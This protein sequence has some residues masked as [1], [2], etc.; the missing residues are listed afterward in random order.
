M[1][2]RILGTLEVADGG[3]V[4]ANLGSPKQRALLA[5]LVLHAGEV[6][7]VD[8]MIDA[9]WPEHAPRTAAH[10]VQ[11]Y[12]S[13]LR[14][15]L[16]R[17]A[18]RDLIAT[19]PS[20]YELGIDQAT[21]DAHRFE[22]LVGDA[23]RCSRD[24]DHE[25]AIDSL[26][27]ALDLWCGPVL[28]DFTYEEF[29]QPHIR[30]L[31][32]RYV[33]AL[34]DLAD[35]ELAAGQP[36]KALAAAEM[37]MAEEPLRERARGTA[38]LALYRLGRHPE[39]LR[40]FENLR[41][42]LADELGLEPS[43]WLQRMQ[44]RIV[45]HDPVLATTEQEGGS[46]GPPLGNPYKGLRP[47][48][49]ADVAD[50]FGR[51]SLVGQLVEMLKS[52]RRLTTIVGPSGSGKSSVLAAGL[53]PCVRSGRAITGSQTWQIVRV[54][55]D[56]SLIGTLEA[57]LNAALDPLRDP[58]GSHQLILIDQFEEL[59]VA[60]NDVVTARVLQLLTAAVTADAPVSVVIALR[61]DFYDRPLLEADFAA[62]FAP[63]VVNVVP[64]TPEELESA[65]VRPAAAAGC[66]VEPRL[67][68]EL[69]A[70]T[71]AQAGALPLVQYALTERFERRS[72][73]R[74]T[75]DDY[76]ALGGLRG[77]L[78]RQ[79]DG[80]YE[81]LDD[82]GQLVA[83]QV[84]LRLVRPVHDKMDL[85]RRVPLSELN[86][87]GLDVVALSTVLEAYGR[88]R[89]IT[90]DR[91]PVTGHATVDLAHEALLREWD[92]FVGWIGRHRASLRRLASLA[93]AADDW[94]DAGRDPDYLLVGSRLSDLDTTPLGSVVQLTSTQRAYLHASRAR[95]DCERLTEAERQR[96]E[97]R[98]VH[99]ARSRLVALVA[100]FAVLAGTI[101]YFVVHPSGAA[102]ASVAL[103]RAEGQ[104][105]WTQII[106]QGFE[107]AVSERGLPSREAAVGSDIQANG[108]MRT[109][110]SQGS[111]LVVV[112]A[113]DADVD[114]V[115]HDF[116]SVH[117]AVIDQP[118]MQ[119]NVTRI[120]FA[121]NE[122]SFLAGVVAASRTHTGTIAFIG[123]A[124]SPVIWAWAAG[125]EAGARAVNPHI[126]ILTTY[127]GGA[128]DVGGYTDLT[129]AKAA[130]TSAYNTGADIIFAAAGDSGLGAFAA[131]T[132]PS[133]NGTQRW[134]IGV[135]SDQYE[136]VTAN[137]ANVD[138]IIW[139][140]HILTSVVKRTDVAVHDLVAR[141]AQGKPLTHIEVFSPANH[142]A[143]VTYSGGFI[144][145]L[146]A[147]IDTWRQ[148]I[149]D[150]Q[151][152]VP[153][154]PTNRVAGSLS[155]D[156]CTT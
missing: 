99:R 29:A 64:L 3:V 30:R 138:S 60:G 122:A 100:T 70:D 79:A 137:P 63:S 42:H 22:W 20:G 12:V 98:L 126:T 150:H 135:D 10:S 155:P 9:L 53:V 81:Q 43:P 1:Q 116:P 109:L 74:L 26:R 101:T 51:E 149:A 140:T 44:E 111:G 156:Y 118:T 151:I 87:L 54:V 45:L 142:G 56:R 14:K 72:D 61:A 27:S 83:V 57:A 35:A 40:T 78:S 7:S 82:A 84:F 49:E 15:V 89:L 25:G 34:E 4:V 104:Y 131:A 8:R 144:D 136:T 90:F 21:V 143:D 119:P 2:F 31:T 107:R 50:F 148:R 41:R 55:P 123:G 124:D 86:D 38:M 39:A 95:H 32:A 17:L 134:V 88:H 105:Q 139:R 141:F 154:I 66:L 13:E 68:A 112:T 85:R 5:L 52:G 28:A 115:A 75:L 16:R 67:L 59:F 23:S 91:D 92:R 147:T 65:I 77:L 130:A 24:G 71:A 152:T 47:F 129:G 19:R 133:T 6:V 94:E 62:V 103:V 33:D 76:R 120:V 80:V 11:I 96:V 114:S 146:R 117:Y 113:L 106:K 93:T 108:A 102:Q 37:T 48:V 121:V 97:Q 132:V 46:P 58:D 145:D 128:T 110:S 69:V 18:G 73:P 125:Y 127:L 153:C 36:A